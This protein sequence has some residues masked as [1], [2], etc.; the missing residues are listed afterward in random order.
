[1]RLAVLVFVVVVV[2]CARAPAPERHE[3]IA[4]SSGSEDELGLADRDHDGY[5][6]ECDLCPDEAETRFDRAHEDGC[7]GIRAIV[8]DEMVSFRWLR[9]PEDQAVWL[10]EHDALARDL[11]TFLAE[12]P[13]WRGLRVVGHA[14]P[15]ERRAEW[16]ASERA[17]LVRDQLIAIGVPAE[18]LFVTS[19]PGGAAEMSE[20]GVEG[21]QS[22]S[23]EAVL[24]E[25]PAA[26]P[27]HCAE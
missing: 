6:D 27:A 20:R 2:G 24:G 11:A 9:F 1:M 13:T 8:L 15:A 5:P 14:S 16:L 22:V 17:V 25:P 3:E 19:A 7:P 26:R 18:L 10:P 23:F 4:D 21:L 12:H